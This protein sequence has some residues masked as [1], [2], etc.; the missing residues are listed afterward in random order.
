MRFFGEL[1]QML[2]RL[3]HPS[4]F[5]A[6][7]GGKSWALEKGL[8]LCCFV[9]LTLVLCNPILGIVTVPGFTLPGLPVRDSMANPNNRG[10]QW[11]KLSAKDVTVKTIFE[12]LYLVPGLHQF[13]PRVNCPI[14]THTAHSPAISRFSSK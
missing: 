7:F 8:L 9:L 2:T 1:G 4:H 12:R 10:P 14:R 11:P 5:S 13:W 6:A 3:P